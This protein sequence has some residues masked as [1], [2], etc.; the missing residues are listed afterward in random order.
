VTFRLRRRGFLLLTASTAGL[1][2]AGGIAY[3]TIPDSGGVI[4]T[5]FKPSD[6]TKIG[7]A[8]LSV[9]DSE[10][11]AICKAGDTALTFN[12]QGPAGPQGPEGP[13]G[14]AGPQGTEGPAGPQGPAGPPGPQ[15]PPGPSGLPMYHYVLNPANYAGYWSFGYND[16]SGPDN[17]DQYQ[18]TLGTGSGPDAQTATITVV[19]WHGA[20]TCQAEA[21]AIVKNDGATQTYANRVVVDASEFLS[22]QVLIDVPGFFD[23]GFHVCSTTNFN[24]QGN[25]GNLTSGPMD[26]WVTPAR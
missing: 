20:D 6:A 11:G 1:A 18:L 2:L 10:G 24:W 12:Q 4:H 16:G 7:G 8:A 22:R 5:C 25:Y 26:V 21:A 3:A 9:V 17:A 19:G 15:G 13:R 14:P 23:L